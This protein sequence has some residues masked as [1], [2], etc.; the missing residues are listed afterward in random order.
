MLPRMS[1][2]Q[3]AAPRVR[4]IGYPFTLGVASGYPRP[5]GVTLWT[6]L[7]PAPLQPDGGMPRTGFDV[8][9]EISEDEAFG[10]IARKGTAQCSFEHVHT[11]HVDVNGLAP[12]RWYWYRFR[13]GQ[14]LSPI[15]RTRTADAPDTAASR[16]RF[17]IGSCQHYEQGYYAAHRHLADENLDLMLFLGDYIYA[18][19]WG[20]DRVRQHACETA[21][22]L[23]EYRSRY[24]QYR[25]DPDLQ[26]MHALVPWAVV[27]DDGEVDNDWAS[28]RSE[29]LDPAFVSRRAAALQ[30]YL[31]H[32]PMPAQLRSNY[33][34][35]SIHCELTYGTLARFY[36]LDDRLHRSYQACPPPEK[37]GGNRVYVDECADLTRADRTML[38]IDQE[39]W[40][41]GTLARA[42]QR[43]NVVA[44][45][46]AFAPLDFEP[47]PR[48]RIGTDW[49]DGYP[50]A[51]SRLIE[52]LVRHR[53]VNPL[54]VG[55]DIH[56]T[57][58]ADLHR[59]PADPSTPIV[60]STFCG[61]SITSQ[62]AP[63][64]SLD[65]RWRANSH[66]KF[67][68][69]H[70]RG[71]VTFDLTADACTARVRL[72]ESEKNRDSAITTAAT[73]EVEAGR[74]GVRAA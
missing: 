2:A 25:L 9:W 64:G 35:P 38:G 30:A 69:T 11:V 43:W 33:S 63:A 50:A 24:V 74:P 14:E 46:T 52:S 47:G 36:L 37:G 56:A 45:Q 58:A 32:M 20:D 44:Q 68:N 21:Y 26:R 73:F 31:E 62:G 1:A 48:T 13:A 67:V 5:D 7:A 61:T 29:Y 17:A 16:L 19:S 34:E 72:L 10:K 18:D 55:G 65:T 49:W 3:S 59:V 8:Q 27:W 22:T 23:D 51:R 53:T 15:G 28:D 42:R 66:V 54:V 70:Q 6:R 71:Y 12:A 60:G 40:L 57:V 4:F 39:R 41:D